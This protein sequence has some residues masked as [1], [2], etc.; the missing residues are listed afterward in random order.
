VNEDFEEKSELF[1]PYAK[2]IINPDE[3][4]IQYDLLNEKKSAAV[5]S[6][7]VEKSWTDSSGNNCLSELVP[8]D[9]V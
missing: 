8:I 5:R 6:Y 1:K 3:T 2:I 9:S 4:C 7:A